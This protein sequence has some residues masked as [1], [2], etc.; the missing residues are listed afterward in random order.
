MEHVTESKQAIT[1]HGRIK[2]NS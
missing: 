2:K 1:Q